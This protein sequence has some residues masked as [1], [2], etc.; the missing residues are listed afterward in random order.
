MVRQRKIIHVDMDAFYASVEQRDQARYKGKPLVVGG[1]PNARGVVAACSYEARKYGIHS[2]MPCSQAY[3]LCPD[4]IFVPPRFDVYREISEQIRVVFWKYASE[5]EPLS[6]DEAYLDVSFTAVFN[7]SATYIAQ[8]IKA[9][10]LTETGLIASAGV[11]YNKFLAK[12]ASDMDK[13]DGLYVIRPE[14]GESFVE[15]LAIGKFHGIGPATEQKMMKLGIETGADLRRW[16]EAA[17]VEHFGKAGSYFYHIARGIDERPVRSQRQRKSIG[18]ETTFQQDIRSLI[19]LK[20]H[21]ENLSDQVWQSLQNHKLKAR[22]VTLK[23]KYA[24]FEQVT[25]S[26]TVDE[27]LSL[28]AIKQLLP[29]LLNKTEAGI[30]AVRLIGVTVSGFEMKSPSA[31]TEQLDLELSDV[32]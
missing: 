15:T 29:E 16:D 19:D 28:Q 30:Q 24:N 27:A 18:K 25:R 32:F 7:G 8:A 21:A 20:A 31:E 14:Q 2:A 1:K 3:R 6:L 17:L 12:L 26:V 4:A 10:I 5:V 11:S 23:I 13:P 9:D 22:T